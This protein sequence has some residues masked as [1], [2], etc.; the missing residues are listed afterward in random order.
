MKPA[1]WTVDVVVPDDTMRESLLLALRSIPWSQYPCVRS[2][3]VGAVVTT[4]THGVEPEPSCVGRWVNSPARGQADGDIAKHKV[5]LAVADVS[6][7]GEVADHFARGVD[8]PSANTLTTAAHYLLPQHISLEALN[9]FMWEQWRWQSLTRTHPRIRVY[10]PLSQGLSG[11]WHA[12][13][14]LGP[15]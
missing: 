5:T 6:S 2:Y 9:R 11:V 13:V 10:A 12:L 3:R 15:T 8:A 4:A 7:D 1:D 14:R